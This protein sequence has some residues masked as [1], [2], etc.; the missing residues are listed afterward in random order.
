M[1]ENNSQKKRRESSE[2]RKAP[3]LKRRLIVQ[4]KIKELP[5]SERAQA[6][7]ESSVDITRTKD[8]SETGISFTAS[9]II[10]SQTILDIKLKLP[11]QKETLSLEGRVVSCDEIEENLIYE[12]RAEFFNLNYKQKEALRNFIH[13]FLKG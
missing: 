2:R 5:K 8:L 12:I 10:P 1:K 9:K 11:I 13:L 3:R 4:Y 7:V 6:S